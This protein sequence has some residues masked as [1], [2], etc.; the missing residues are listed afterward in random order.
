[1]NRNHLKVK[2]V[3]IFHFLEMINSQF[4]FVYVKKIRLNK[5]A[6]LKADNQS[7]SGLECENIYK[8]YKQVE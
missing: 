4:I 3:Y 8:Q 1:M 5:V 2:C 7:F 6:R